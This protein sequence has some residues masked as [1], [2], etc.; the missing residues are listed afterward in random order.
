MSLTH[1]LLALSCVGF[2][3][4]VYGCDGT[5]R[6]DI[7]RCCRNDGPCSVGEGDCNRDSECADGLR[8]GNNNCK[9]DFSTAESVWRRWDDCCYGRFTLVLNSN[10]WKGD[11]IL[12]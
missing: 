1:I 7:W 6:W 8:C 2:I 12:K 4:N 10:C 9:N 3:S 5:D 11:S